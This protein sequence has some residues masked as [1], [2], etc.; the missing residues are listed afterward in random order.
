MGKISLVSAKYII[1][2]TINIDGMVDRP[3]VIGSVFGQT[4][5]LLG[6]DLELR[7]LQSSGRIGR[8]EVETHSKDGKTFG[9]IS[10]PSSLD[11][12]ETALVAAALETIL[13]I[14][15]CNAEVKVTGLEDVRAAKRDQLIDRA[16]SLL[17]TF[18]HGTLPDSREIKEEVTNAVRVADIVKYGEDQLPAGPDVENAESVILVEGRADVI[19]LLKYD[20]KNAVSMNGTSVPKTVIE[21]AKSKEVTVFVDGDRGGDLIIKE[22]A[23]VAKIDFVAKAPDGKEVEEITHKEIHQALRG[24]VSLKA[25]LEYKRPARVKPRVGDTSE[26]DRGRSE[27]KPFNRNDRR[28]ERKPFDRSERKPFDRSERKPFDRSERKPFNRNDR[29][30][31]N[32]RFN[33]RDRYPDREF[34]IPIKQKEKFIDLIKEMDG[35]K[36]ACLLDGRGNILGKVPAKEAASTM[37]GLGKATSV[38]IIDGSLTKELLTAAENARVRYLIGKK[39]YLKDVKSQVKVFTKKDLC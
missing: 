4:E 23:E 11:K 21:M 19:N 29:K 38:V 10:I 39:S 35:T 8:I 1:H 17:S 16:K 28:P 36:N 37:E 13:R 33:S 14:G 7:E 9:E 20:I 18:T 27:R 26:R 3:D 22:L 24:K 31:S 5:G 6:S 34:R 25:A 32:G 12:T 2:A 15:P 30:P